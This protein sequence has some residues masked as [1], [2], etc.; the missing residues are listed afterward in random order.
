MTTLRG[1][2]V[3]ILGAGAVG[4]ALAVGL[5][6]AGYNVTAITSRNTERARMLSGLVG[7]AIHT[8]HAGLLVDI[9]DIVVLTVPDDV[10]STV[11]ESVPWRSGMAAVHCSGGTPVSV[12][13]C[14]HAYGAVIGGFHPLQTFPREARAPTPLENVTFAIESQD[15]ALHHQLRDM[16]HALHGHAIDINEKSRALYHI[17]GVLASNYL[18]AIIAEA[19]GLWAQFGYNQSQALQALLP[20]VRGTVGN[21]ERDGAAAALT[22]PIVRGDL[23]TVQA[24]LEQLRATLPSVVPLYAALAQA[25]AKFAVDAQRLD[26]TR[27]AEIL[28]LVGRESS[29][30][31][32]QTNR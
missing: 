27:G 28:A 30:T 32:G 11:A 5:S 15:P 8:R 1:D 23:G 26:G 12:L 16:A 2:R 9:A 20:L 17:S 13:E 29:E 22:G 6:E 14:A 18:V 21:I 3:G 4:M 25:T 10:I 31:T 7:G 19:A 24:H